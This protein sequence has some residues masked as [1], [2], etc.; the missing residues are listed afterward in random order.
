MVRPGDIHPCLFLPHNPLS[1]LCLPLQ[2]L[3]EYL[4]QLLGT[5]NEGLV[6]FADNVCRYQQGEPLE[7]NVYHEDQDSTK[8]LDVRREEAVSKTPPTLAKQQQKQQQQQQPTKGAEVGNRRRQNQPT[9]SRVPPPSKNISKRSPPPPVGGRTSNTTPASSQNQTNN[10][11][12]MVELRAT[13]I[14]E[15][16]RERDVPKSHPS[17]GKASIVCG[18]FGTRHQALTNCLYC[19][20]ISCI[21]E[22]YGFCA[23][24]GLMVDEIKDASYVERIVV[25]RMLSCRIKAFCITLTGIPSLGPSHTVTKATRHGCRRKDSYGLIENLR[26]GRKY[27]TTKPTIRL[28]R[29]G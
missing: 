19:G 10:L 25:K 13:P 20:R 2:D 15:E 14:V 17:R 24:C 3:S 9:K 7:S 1:P 27:W 21:V 22:G 18:C 28:P 12:A 6:E 29:R 5:S 16:K 11:T 23:F 4:S 26:E 8:K